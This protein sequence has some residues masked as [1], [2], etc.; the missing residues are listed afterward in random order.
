MIDLWN[1]QPHWLKRVRLFLGIVWRK[2]EGKRMPVSTS[3]QVALCM[4]PRR[5]E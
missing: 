4:H 3:W 5:K 1:L 2:Y